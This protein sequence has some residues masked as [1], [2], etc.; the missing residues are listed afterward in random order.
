MPTPSFAW[1][2][3]QYDREHGDRY[4]THVRALQTVFTET[5]GDISPVG[6]AC[7]AWRLATLP[8]LD[9]GYVRLHR[10]VISAVCERN[11]WDG[12]LTARIQLIAPP[13]EPL[14]KTQVWGRDRGWKG[15]PVVMGQYLEPSPEELSRFPFVRPLL[16]IDAPVPL[17]DLPP[18]PEEAGP[19]LA[20]LATRAVSVLARELNELMGPVISAL[21]SD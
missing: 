8:Y 2:D 6:F 13:P 4:A 5:Y 21:E 3:Q 11:P 1:I 19:E 14:A 9:P 16:L 15:W 17:T 18:A 20:A 10:R 7:T 12:S